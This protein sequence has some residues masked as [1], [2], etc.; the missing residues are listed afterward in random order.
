MPLARPAAFVIV[1]AVHGS[2]IPLQA[3][4]TSS[5]TN[6]KQKPQPINSRQLIS[7]ARRKMRYGDRGSA[8]A[9]L[10]PS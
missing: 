9:D 10:L 5:T 8:I 1:I 3:A 7:A 2:F 4:D 6:G